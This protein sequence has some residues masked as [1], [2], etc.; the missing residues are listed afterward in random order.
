MFKDDNFFGRGPFHII[1]LEGCTQNLLIESTLQYLD[2][3]SFIKRML[4]HGHGKLHIS[5]TS[6]KR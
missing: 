2:T 4:V 5:K 6:D 3:I 1:N